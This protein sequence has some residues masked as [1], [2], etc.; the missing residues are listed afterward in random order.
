[1]V[2]LKKRYK[3][4]LYLDEAHSIGAL[5]RTGRGVTEHYGIDP[6]DVDVAMG[7]FTKSFGSAGGYIAGKKSL[8]NWLR[9]NS[10]SAVY[11]GNM[12]PVICQQIITVLRTLMD[13]DPE[14]EGQKRINQLAWNTRYF[15]DALCRKKFIVY[16][17][18]ASPVVPI[19]VFIPSKIPA[20]SRACQR[21]GIGIVVVGYP[22][23]PLI[24]SRARF[25]ISAAHTKEMLDKALNVLD[26]MADN[27]RL[28]YSRLPLPYWIEEKDHFESN[29]YLQEK[30]FPYTENSSQ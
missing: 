25:C 8:I 16:G 15:R 6:G 7:T 19:L 5:G 22:A 9:V 1:V 3:A 20:L 17:N 13:P 21:R 10:H 28:R 26:D 24:L 30:E 4:Y 2:A 14:K 11:G 18:R 12:S 29:S 27:F 23:T